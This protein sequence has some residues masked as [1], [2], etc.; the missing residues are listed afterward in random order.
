MPNGFHGSHADWQQKTDELKSLESELEFFASENNLDVE[1]HERNWPGWSGRSSSTVNL[2]VQ[3]YLDGEENNRWHLWVC[4]W[5]DREDGRYMKS[6]KL[7]DSVLLAEIESGLP[8][9]L[10]Q[11]WQDV[12]SWSEADLRAS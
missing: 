5:Q 9:L 2:L 4:A 7:K 6:R 11:A 12:S 3:I 10:Q 8:S 1:W